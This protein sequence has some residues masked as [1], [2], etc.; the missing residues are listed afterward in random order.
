[1]FQLEVELDLQIPAMKQNQVGHYTNLAPSSIVQ[2]AAII[3]LI[4]V[5]ILLE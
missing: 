4:H 2:G 1:M 3:A 5:V